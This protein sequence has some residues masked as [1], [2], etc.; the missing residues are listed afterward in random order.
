M[1]CFRKLAKSLED[2][3]V[4]RIYEKLKRSMKE[5]KLPEKDMWWYLDTRKFGSVPHSGFGLGF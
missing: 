3:S 5:L 1:Y 2:R 4:K